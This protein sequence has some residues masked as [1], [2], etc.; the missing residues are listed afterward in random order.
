MK[1]GT[2]S[3]ADSNFCSKCGSALVTGFKSS[4]VNKTG[5][6][7][8]W[9][10]IA[11][12]VLIIVVAIA[13]LA[14]LP[15]PR[16]FTEHLTSAYM[17]PGKATFSPPLGSQITGRWSTADGGSVSFNIEDANANEIYFADSS[18]GSFSFTASNPPYYFLVNSAPTESISVSGTYS[19][20]LL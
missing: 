14:L 6:G 9:R 7:H 12:A 17:N 20:P 19:S 11:I 15:V 13:V 10:N 1:C 18:G 8:R 4:P 16:P 5:S 3:Q 2:S